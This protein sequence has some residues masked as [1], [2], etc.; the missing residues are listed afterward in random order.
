MFVHRIDGQD[1]IRFANE[2]WYAFARENGADGLH[3]GT[4]EGRSLWEF[5]DHAETRMIF[6]MLVQRVRG[7]GRITLSFRCDS[8]RQRRF[9]GLELAALPEQGVE[10]RS[11]ILRVEDREWMG[12]F[13]AGTKR[14]GELLRV[15]SWCKKVDVRTHGW[16][17]VEQAVR[18][19]RLFEA[20]LLPA[21]THGICESCN[22]DMLEAIER[23]LPAASLS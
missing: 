1:R 6:E 17:E 10:F 14:S 23:T 18:A 22:V 12:L 2:H 9:M 7:G 13:D 20:P 8:P 15:C 16:L 21:I 4:V 11:R 19:L 5:I 3:A